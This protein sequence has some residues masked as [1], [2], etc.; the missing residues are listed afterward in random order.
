[1]KCGPCFASGY[2]WVDRF[3]Y[4]RR[5]TCMKN[6]DDLVQ[7]YK[8]F[9]YPRNYQSYNWLRI[10]GGEPLLNDDYVQFLF[11]AIIKISEIDSQKFNNG[12][13]I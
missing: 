8:M 10:L 6:L 7:D 12:V 4:N 1:M 5:V 2:S 13:I 3:D 9:P 11:D